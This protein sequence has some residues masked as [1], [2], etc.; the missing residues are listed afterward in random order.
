VKDDRGDL[1]FPTQAAAKFNAEANRKALLDD[2]RPLLRRLK[3]KQIYC[4]AR[5]VTFKDPSFARAHPQKAILNNRTGKPYRSTDDLMWVSPHDADF[6]E[7]NLEIAR[8]AAAAGFQEIQFDYIRFPDVARSASLNYRNPG[9]QTKAQ[10]V[11][12]FLL[13]ARRRLSPMKAYVAADVFG[14]V[15]TTADDM[16][17]GQYW[18]AVS[19]AVDYICPMMY[20]SHYANR[21]YGLRVPDQQ[22]YELIDRGVRDALRRN[23]NLATPARVRPWIQG[24]TASWLKEHREYGVAEVKAQIKALADNGVHSY[25]IWTP[26]NRYEKQAYR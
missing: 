10:V 6:R 15:C 11:Q 17:I 1:L 13:E 18:E 16:D 19:N 9:N 5:I 23:Q 3:A 8:E 25:L 12:N 26:S 7:Y 4:V 20:P 21:S 24:F 2:V 22:P 14:L